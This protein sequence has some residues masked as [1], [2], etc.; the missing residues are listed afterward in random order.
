MHTSL[1]VLFTCVICL[2]SHSPAAPPN[3]FTVVSWN[4]DSDDADAHI[5]ALR[6][7]E[8]K[9]VDLWGFSEVPDERW[10]RLLEAAAG[11]N[12]PGNFAAVLSPTRGR[13]RSL[14]AYDV[15]RFELLG[16]SELSWDDEPWRDPNAVLR[17]AVIAR[18]RHIATE[19]EFF[20]MVN[21]LHPQ[22]AGRQAARLERWAAGQGIPVIAVGSYYFQY[23]LGPE[24]L[25]CDGQMGLST[26]VG[27][28][29]FDW[30][31][32]ANLVKTCDGQFN[33]IEDFVFLANAAGKLVGRTRVIVEPGDFPDD[34][35]TS[36]HRPILAV[37]A[38]L[39]PGSEAMLRKQIVDQVR[40]IQAELDKLEA[41][42]RQLP[43]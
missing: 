23:N 42:V 36:D 26:M 32:P 15:G 37:F 43:D 14:I 1:A 18:F 41:L 16:Y 8:M 2:S 29:V 10:A 17:P 7:A 40:R 5:A 27:S 9:G 21:R 24:P 20:F 28:G 19:Q 35:S 39:R 12:E 13:D 3:Q 31:A 33:T 38:I 4:V 6:V 34:E 25:R 30:L 22:W 11:D